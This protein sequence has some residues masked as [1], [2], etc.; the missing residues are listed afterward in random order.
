[1]DDKGTEVF[2]VATINCFFVSESLLIVNSSTKDFSNGA[3]GS[4][5]V[6]CYY[7]WGCRHIHDSF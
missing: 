4:D 2:G 6:Y 7:V 1:M 5:L 3:T